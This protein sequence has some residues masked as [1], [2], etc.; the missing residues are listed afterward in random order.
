MLLGFVTTSEPRHRDDA[1][2]F[3]G[4]PGQPRAAPGESPQGLL[5]FISPSI[6][7]ANIIYMIQW[8]IKTVQL[9]GIDERRSKQRGTRLTHDDCF[10]KEFEK[11]GRK[12]H[13]HPFCQSRMY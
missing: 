10:G 3:H 9:G 13:K 6:Y 5:L 11:V 4:M 1:Q 2:D 7:Q 12:N 8:P